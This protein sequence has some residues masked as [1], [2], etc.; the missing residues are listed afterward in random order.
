MIRVVRSIEHGKAKPIEHGKAKPF[1]AQKTV[2]E[3]GSLLPNRPLAVFDL[4]GVIIDTTHRLHHI[5]EIV[6]GVQKTKTDAESWRVFHSLA[7]LDVPGVCRD[8]ALSL[9]NTHHVIFLTARVMF[10]RQI[11]NALI[12][13]LHEFGFKYVNLI[14]RTPD[15]NST[16]QAT[17]FKYEVLKE[18]LK[19]STIALFADD[20][21]KTCASCKDLGIPILR[22]YNHLDPSAYT[23]W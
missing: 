23:S 8:L 13:K 17:N 1:V 2:A 4:D 19:T 11:E 12:T 3:I 20:S 9:S 16:C 22:V 10:D 18:L 7:H 21:H 5:V 15:N 14:A 6:D